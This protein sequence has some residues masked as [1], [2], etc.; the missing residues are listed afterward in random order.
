MC[1]SGV[2]SDFSTRD[3]QRRRDRASAA[4]PRPKCGCR[5]QRLTRGQSGLAVA[6]RSHNAGT[7]FLLCARSRRQSCND[8]VPPTAPVPHLPLLPKLRRFS[9]LMH[10][11]TADAPPRSAW[12]PP[13]VR[14]NS[15]RRSSVGEATVTGLAK[16][17]R[18]PPT[19]RLGCAAWPLSRRARCCW[20][21]AGCCWH[22]LGWPSPSPPCCTGPGGSS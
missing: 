9:P 3:D 20:L 15:S 16:G 1:I 4:P 5:T 6:S 17:W 13:R 14:A 22:R 12:Q 8:A 2:K 7:C 21:S 11:G 19:A 10:S 18:R